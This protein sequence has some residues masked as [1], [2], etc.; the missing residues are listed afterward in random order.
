MNRHTALILALLSAGSL[1]IAEDV[2]LNN[3]SFESGTGSYWINRPAMA[4]IDSSES[5]DGMKCLAVTPEAG[6]TVSTVF[7]TV[8]RKDTVF[9]LSF[10]AKTNTPANGPQLSLA[11]MLQGAK[12]ICFFNSDRQQVKA[13]ST[14][15]K[16]TTQW[17]TLKYTI[18]PIPEKVMNQ[19]VKRLMF[20][21][22]VKGGAQN[23]KV[24]ID[25]IKLKANAKAPAAQAKAPAKAPAKAAPAK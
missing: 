24:W 3:P 15:A 8:Q 17:Q 4:R 1:V 25:N 14:P 9:E 19:E 21:V 22:N 20:Y 5:S 7:N 11:L 16:L 6:K 12:P 2:K 10:D 18:G 23:G 13:L